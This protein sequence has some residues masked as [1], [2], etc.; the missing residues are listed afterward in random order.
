[1]NRSGIHRLTGGGGRTC[2]AQLARYLKGKCSMKHHSTYR[3]TGA[4]MLLIALLAGLLPAHRASASAL[5]SSTSVV[6]PAQTVRESFYIANAL[7][8]LTG[9]RRYEALAF[10]LILQQMY[11]QN[12]G[13]PAADAMRALL[14]LQDTYKAAN[15][16][17]GSQ[18]SKT[19]NEVING[20]FTTLTT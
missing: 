10:G 4:M 5:Q 1:M 3:K 6:V 17:Q 8:R 9:T 2:A 11:R 12:P 13:L 14:A 15:Q 7:D 16:S 20:I 18:V 19:A